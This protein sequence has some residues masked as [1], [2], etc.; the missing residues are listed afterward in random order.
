MPVISYTPSR[1]DIFRA[2]TAFLRNVLPAGTPTRQGEINRVPEPHADDFV[3]YW[4]LMQERLATNLDECTDAVFTGSIAG[5]TMTITAVH[6]DF[7]GQI[8]VGSVIFGEGVA[9][10]TVVTAFGTGTGGLGTYTVSRSQ[11]IGSRT[12]AAGI[13]SLQQDQDVQIQVDVHGNNSISNASL[14]STVFRD[15]RGIE[16]FAGT[17]M[18]PLFADDPRQ[19][20]FQ[21]AEQQWEIR[22]V[23]TL[24]LQVNFKLELPQQFA[25]ELHVTTYDVDASYP[26]TV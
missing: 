16:M 15:A 6:P 25:D 1:S 26:P 20:P 7:I 22:L 9:D 11:N 4:M 19:V 5:T 14:I 18:T 2:V 10:D 13:E 21:N 12:L 23:V 17:E 24:H 8:K 3:V